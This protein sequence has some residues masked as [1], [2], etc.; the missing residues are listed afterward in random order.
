[1]TLQKGISS[2]SISPQEEGKT[3]EMDTTYNTFGITTQGLGPRSAHV[4]DF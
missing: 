2:M 4:Q 3:H 1:M